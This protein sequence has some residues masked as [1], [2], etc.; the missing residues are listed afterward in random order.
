MPASYFVTH[1][2]VNS[3]LYG[4][5]TPGSPLTSLPYNNALFVDPTYGDNSTALRERQDLPFE[6]VAAAVAAAQNNDTI[7]L[8]PG[9]HFVTSPIDISATSGI[10]NLGIV[11]EGGL[12]TVTNGP[13]FMVNHLV[14][15]SNIV[16]RGFGQINFNANASDFLI[17]SSTALSL[18]LD[19]DFLNCI[20]GGLLKAPLLT[21]A[22]I[23]TRNRIEIDTANTVINVNAGILNFSSNSI[24]YS[25]AGTFALLDGVKKARIRSGIYTTNDPDNVVLDDGASGLTAKCIVCEINYIEQTAAISEP[26]FKIGSNPVFLNDVNIEVDPTTSKPPILLKGDHASLRNVSISDIVLGSVCIDSDTTATIRNLTLQGT[27][28]CNVPLSPDVELEVDSGNDLGRSIFFAWNNVDSGSIA[29]APG[30]NISN[31]RTDHPDYTLNPDGSIELHFRGK[32]K[33]RYE[34]NTVKTSAGRGCVESFITLNGSERLGTRTAHY[35]ETNGCASEA[36]VT[37]EITVGV[38]DTL[39]AASV[40]IAGN[41]SILY[42]ARGCRIHIE[43]IG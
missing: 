27:N 20:S 11:F 12:L 39:H 7:V 21:E 36:T 42:K 2:F 26:L 28:I 16:M 38:G 29:T 31:I 10:N 40:I 13:L 25:S 43:R 14:E 22:N 24:N 6:T 32:I 3:S 23:I 15:T 18:S 17:D 9:P 8:R 1:P 30:P 37:D 35:Q 5:G 34:I 4:G 41:T 19:V 33:V